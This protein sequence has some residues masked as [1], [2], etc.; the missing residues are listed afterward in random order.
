MRRAPRIDNSSNGLLIAARAASTARDSP[1]PYQIP[2]SAFPA[3]C[4]TERTS[5]KSTLINPG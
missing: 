1:D 4:I 2:M 5:A 3:S